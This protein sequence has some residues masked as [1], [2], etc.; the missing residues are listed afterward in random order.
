MRIPA[1]NGGR[2]HAHK[3]KEAHHGNWPGL[4]G[5]LPV[6]CVS[7]VIHQSNDNANEALI[8]ALNIIYG[9]L[10]VS[11]GIASVFKYIIHHESLLSYLSS[12]VGNSR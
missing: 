9:P 6:H 4:S 7:Q 10:R 1:K 11:V 3:K 12:K 2:P 5:G 8:S